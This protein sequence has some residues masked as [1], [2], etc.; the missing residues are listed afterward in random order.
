MK[1]LKLVLV[2]AVTLLFLGMGSASAQEKSSKMV[3]LRV[4]E[5]SGA[6]TGLVT[7]DSEGE[8]NKIALEKGHD[9]DIAASNGLLIQ[10]ELEKWKQN[11]YQITHLSTSG[12]T[13]S[14]TTIILEK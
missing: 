13:V 3:I 11:G 8:I 12:E 9:A 4:V 5:G 6:K 7:I 2:V 10:K 14:R 1:K